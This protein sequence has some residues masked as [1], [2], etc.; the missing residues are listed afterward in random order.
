MLLRVTGRLV[1]ISESGKRNSNYTVTKLA[2]TRSYHSAVLVLAL[3]Y[4]RRF[5]LRLAI[6]VVSS[7]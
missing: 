4:D 7:C 6:L 5:S 2:H 3:Q 1:S